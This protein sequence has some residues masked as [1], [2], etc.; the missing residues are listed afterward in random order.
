[1]MEYTDFD[2]TEPSEEDNFDCHLQQVGLGSLVCRCAKQDGTS[3]ATNNVTPAIC[4]SCPIGKIFREVGCD[5]PSTNISVRY[6][7]DLPHV[8]ISGIFC[9]IRKRYTTFEYC[10][11]CPL[12][13]AESTKQIIQATRGL[14]QSSKFY[15]AYQDIEKAR[16]AIRDGEFDRSIT[17]SI[18]CVESTCRLIHDELGEK[19]PAE[20]SLSVLWKSTRKVLELDALGSE[21]VIVQLLNSLF[22]IV[23]QLGAMRNALSDAHGKGK[24]SHQVS[25]SYA[26]LALNTASTIATF[27]VRHF[28]TKGIASEE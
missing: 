6:F 27:A 7:S 14:F 18:A 2:I 28:K 5:A 16:T 1:M 4:F 17:H 3:N 13:T 15:A 8:S 23:N 9:K 26:E 20:K 22:G 24:H 25:E 12:V 19:L 10:Q 11:S 21:D